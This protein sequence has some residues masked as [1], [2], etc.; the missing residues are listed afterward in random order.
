PESIQ[1]TTIH[2]HPGETVYTV[3]VA[4]D[5]TTQTFI[6]ARL[7]VTDVVFAARPQAVNTV[8]ADAG[9][10]EPPLVFADSPFLTFT[11]QPANSI[12]GTTISSGD[13]PVQVTAQDA[14]GA[15]I[16][17]MAVTI[18]IG[19]NPGGG[20]LSGTKTRLTDATGVATFDDLSINNPGSG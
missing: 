19:T 12:A 6:D 13:G 18:S 15:V 10:T 2:L 5:P 16:P 11:A 14:S 17:G 8:D 7:P 20:T 9:V 4:F 1:N 3:L